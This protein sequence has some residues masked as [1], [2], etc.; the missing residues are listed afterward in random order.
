M[1]SRAHG[2]ALGRPV[3]L[4]AVQV[5]AGASVSKESR[6]LVLMLALAELLAR[7]GERI[8]WPGVTDPF[9]ARNAAERLAAASDAHAADPPACPDRR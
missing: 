2:L 3:A 1:G 4:D 7:S 6:A 9:S 5:A 8:G